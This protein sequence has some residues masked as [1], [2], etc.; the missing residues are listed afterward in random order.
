VLRFPTSFAADL[1]EPTA[2]TTEVVPPVLLER[3]KMDKSRICRPKSAG[4]EI[5]GCELR[6]EI[7]MQPLATCGP[8]CFSRSTHEGG[9]D[10][11]MLITPAGLGIEQKSVVGA[12]P[13]HVHET[14]EG[15]ARRACCHP[16]EAVGPDPIPPVGRNRITFGFEEFHHLAVADRT[17]PGVVDIAGH[18]IK[19][20]TGPNFRPSRNTGS[21]PDAKPN[22]GA[23]PYP[24]RTLSPLRLLKL[25]FPLWGWAHWSSAGP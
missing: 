2:A 20:D 12:V 9:T 10:A 14:D 3:G 4:V 16:A 15:A 6:L 7:N 13:G 8:G 25:A 1:R 22:V 11:T 23:L 5:E 19:A 18:G 21:R 17:P 24:E